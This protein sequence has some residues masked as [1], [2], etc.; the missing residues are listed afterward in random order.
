[1]FG[2]MS[3]CYVIHNKYDAENSSLHA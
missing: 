1:M 2:F 3:A